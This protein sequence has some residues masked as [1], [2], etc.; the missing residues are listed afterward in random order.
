MYGIIE[1][2][3]THALNELIINSE[4][5]CSYSR[6]I[7]RIRNVRFI[8]RNKQKQTYLLNWLGI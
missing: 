3:R 2:N 6:A 4:Y 1:T 8:C 7:I 5:V